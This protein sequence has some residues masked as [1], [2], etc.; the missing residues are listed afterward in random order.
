MDENFQ[1]K[2][3]G[4]CRPHERKLKEM[5]R[6]LRSIRD[7]EEMMKSNLEV[8]NAWLRGQLQEREIQ[9]AIVASLSL[10]AI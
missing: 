1:I 4:G 2:R 10:E 8:E 7:K 9:L 5:G 3:S 6:E